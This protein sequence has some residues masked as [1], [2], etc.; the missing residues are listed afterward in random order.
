MENKFEEINDE[1]I[2]SL[3]KHGLLKLKLESDTFY[4]L[5]SDFYN[6]SSDITNEEEEI[7]NYFLSMIGSDKND[8]ELI[9]I[10]LTP[11]QLFNI[12]II[13]QRIIKSKL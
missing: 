8:E 4:V 6:N 1:G 11:I 13:G 7:S 10:N 9:S 5:P 12:F 3:L 2:V